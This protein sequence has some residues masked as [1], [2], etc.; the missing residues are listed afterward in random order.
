MEMMSYQF[1]LSCF[2]ENDGKLSTFEPPSVLGFQVNRIFYIFEIPKGEE[3]ANHACM[4]SSIVFIALSGNVTLSVETEEGINEYTL[5]N[6]TTAVFA[7]S[8]SWIRAYNFSKDAVLVGMSDRKYS[9][10]QYENDY[11]RYKEIIRGKTK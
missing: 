3:R 2:G 10:C 8:G 9:D 6:K 1:E 11:G 5:G 7:P 4:N